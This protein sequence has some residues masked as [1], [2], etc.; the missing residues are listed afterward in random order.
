M[1]SGPYSE[2]LRSEESSN[3]FAALHRKRQLLS[4]VSIQELDPVYSEGDGSE[5]LFHLSL[6]DIGPHLVQHAAERV[7]LFRDEDRFIDAGGVL[8]R[9]KLHGGAALR[10]ELPARC[11]LRLLRFVTS[12][13]KVES[14]KR[15]RP[16]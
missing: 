12:M 9:D 13:R 6:Q 4:F 15:R 5:I 10:L 8:K 11:L 1:T 7:I 2:G 14:Q 16:R 3:H